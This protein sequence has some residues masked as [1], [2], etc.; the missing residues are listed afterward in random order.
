[1][2]TTDLPSSQG[3]NEDPT[4]PG[5]EAG[6][7]TIILTPENAEARLA[8]SEVAEWLHEQSEEPGMRKAQDHA[9]KYMWISP[10]QARDAEATR[11]LRRLVT[12]D[13][14]SSSPV[15][16]PQSKPPSHHADEPLEP[17]L[18]LWNGFYF[19]TLGQPPRQPLRGWTAG[20][21]RDGQSL[22][23][24]VLCLR[25]GHDAV[26]GVRR[27]QAILQI[28]S[29]GFVYIQS[30]S[31]RAHTYVNGNRISGEVHLLNEAAMT[32]TFGALRYRAEYA[33]FARSEDYP[34]RLHHYLHKVLGAQTSQ[35]VLALTPT[36]SE[37]GGIK[38]GQWTLTTGTIGSGASG[39][40]SV[41]MNPKGKLVA[42]KRTTVGRDRTQVH[43]LRG[44][45]EML[46][47]LAESHDENRLLRLIEM[48]TDDAKGANS[49]A[50]LWFVLEPA[51]ADT[52][53]SISV[54]GLLAARDER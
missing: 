52:L 48:I 4:L 37:T 24:L 39:R 34:T 17:E 27:H 10:N 19:L 28:H 25:S 44:K 43:E 46:A 1:M 42:L 45:L 3:T 11:L 16:S 32:V 29:T 23:D 30:T 20:S 7:A 35:S 9:R 12:G 47:S 13:L 40:V 22:N 15:S 54:K 38:V 21:L 18:E 31:D 8:F 50:D 2:N 26:Y 14:S 49:T 41:G 36:P 5:S 6:E 51:V 53:Y 33:R